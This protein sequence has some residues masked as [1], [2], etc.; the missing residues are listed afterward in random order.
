MTS[1]VVAAGLVGPVSGPWCAAGRGWP[2][3]SPPGGPRWSTPATRRPPAVAS[4]WWWWGTTRPSTTTAWTPRR[5]RCGPGRGCSPPTTTP[6]TRRTPAVRPGGGA[7]LASIVT[8][9]G[10]VP[11]WPASPTGRW[12]RWSLDRLGRDGVMVGDRPETDG[13]FA[14][15]LGY[16]FGLVLSGVT[17]EADLPDRPTRRPGGRRLASPGGR[18]PRPMSARRRLDAELVRRGLAPSRE[19]AQADIAAGRV[20][21]GGAPAAKAGPAG[22]PGEAVV[23]LGPPR[24]RGP[25]RREAR[26]R[27]RALRVG[28]C[29]PAPGARLRRVHRRLHR[30]P[31]AARRRRGGGGR[32]GPRPAPRAAAGRPRVRDHE[33][34]NV[35][36][37]EPGVSA[38]R[39]TWSSAT[40]RS[41]RCGRCSTRS[42]PWPGRAPTWS[43][44]VKPQ[45]EA[46]RAEVAG[47]GASSPTPRCGDGCS[48]RSATAL[49]AAEPTIMGAMVSPLTGA[50][51]NVEFLVSGA[52][53]AREPVAG[54]PTLA[55]RRARRSRPRSCEARRR[56]RPRE[57]GADGQRRARAAPRPTRGGQGRA[58]TPSTG[59]PAGPRRPPARGRRRHRRARRARRA[60]RASCARASTW[61]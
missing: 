51:G 6:P 26:G 31:A 25:G 15:A 40:C 8:A 55:R 35:R 47:E 54:R 2:R 14:A 56:R 23:V 1:A 33:R 5:P 9:A 20:T 28:R 19:R 16:R 12:R 42:S 61:R 29:S 27:A 41:S 59:S 37:L 11:R 43:L 38:S 52:L 13:R 60:P 36:T 24:V 46:G 22:R 39:P 21:V 3:R 32:R 4:T 49:G 34:T 17:A 18:R 53:R 30:L 7:I 44:L 45:F 57:V 58:S 48:A 50:D 10:A